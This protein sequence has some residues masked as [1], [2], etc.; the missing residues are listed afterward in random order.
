MK[1]ILLPFLLSLIFQLSS[2][3]QCAGVITPTLNP[4][5]S[6][7]GTYP[8]GSVV[9]L[10]VVMDGWLGTD[11][12]NNWIEG[13]GLNLGSGW[14]N[15]TPTLYPNDCNSFAGSTDQWLWVENVTS[16]VTGNS[17]GPGFFFE[18]PAGPVDGDP[19][20]DY[21]DNGSTCIWEFCV[22][23]TASN[24]PTDDLSL[25]VNIY[26]DGDM[27]SWDNQ[28]TSDDCIGEDPSVEITPPGTVVGC[29]VYGCINPIACNFNP[30]AGCDDGSCDLPGCTDPLAC[31]YD[32]NAECD[33]GS[34]TYGGCIDPLAC[35]FNPLAG[36]DDGTCNYFI[37]G[38]ITHNL[39]PCPDTV[40][41][42][43]EV[44]YAVT[45]NQSSIYD[46]HITGGGLV[47]TDQTNDCEI[48]WGN[49]PGTYEITVQEIT[50]QGC[51][52]DIKTCDVKVIVPDI[53]FDTSQYKM[54]LNGSIRLNA[55]PL[56]GEWISNDMNGNTF[57]GTSPGTYYPS[58]ITNIHGCDIQ[59]EVE[60][61]VKRKYEAPDIIYSAELI[62]FCNDLYGQNYAADDSIGVMYNWF[63]DDVRQLTTDNQLSVQ[64]Y[65]TTQT[66]ILKVIAYD[67]IGCESEPKLISVRTETCQRFF[68]PNSFTP[69]GDG[70]NDVFMISGLSVYQPNLKIFNRWGVEVYVSS[71]LYWTGDGGG[72]YYCDNG[73]YNWIIEYRDK[74]GQNKQESGHVILVR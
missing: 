46:W 62:N 27:G 1:K 24:I 38:D 5:P 26:S 6:V 45:G 54:C 67:E 21:G 35:N 74:L 63:I 36:C 39:I 7:N 41:T 72:G 12:G 57:L 71:N 42:G 55:E 53:T 64:W 19:G 33:D 70:I 4:Q 18:G 47:T 69:N 14:I 51:I 11:M 73:V 65:D 8:P 17:A 3:P 2:Y 9:T 44:N 49:V 23:L 59:E 52:G 30:L 56:G 43:L 48:I 61:I 58:Y 50:E 28:P 60:V 68:A 31:N 10:C 15:G 25:S 22:D 66:Y 40:C 29:I 16:S 32:L 20:N 37:M 34:C 13:F